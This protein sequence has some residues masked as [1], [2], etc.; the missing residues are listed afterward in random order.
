MEIASPRSWIKLTACVVFYAWALNLFAADRLASALLPLP[1]KMEVTAGQ[2]QITPHTRIYASPGS[3]ATA[4]QLAAQL[5]LSTGY[6]LKVGVKLWARSAVTDGIFF[7]TKSA[8]PGLGGEGYELTV[9]SNSVVVRAPQQAGLFYGAQTLRQLLP[10]EIFST[11]QV[12][13]SWL[14]PCVQIRDWPRFPWRGLMLDVSRHF[15]NVDEVKRILDLMAMHKL[16]RFHMHLVDSQGWRI[17][18]KK[19]PKLTAVGAWRTR[20]D[21]T[22]P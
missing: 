19:Y 4:R 16:N 9:A 18:I 3:L 20:T 8:D 2:F 1:Q 21:L 17:E 15:Y 7:T 5:R 11:N 6:P 13:M 10:P 12:T 14:M 22:A